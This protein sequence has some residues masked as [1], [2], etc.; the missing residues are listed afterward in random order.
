MAKKRALVCSIH[1]IG[2][3]I[4]TLPLISALHELGYVVDV[5]YSPSRGAATIFK[6]HEKVQRFIDAAVKI[7]DYDVACCTQICMAYHKFCVISQ[8]K[9]MITPGLAPPSAT[10]PLGGYKKHEVA[11]NLD[12]AIQLGYPREKC[13]Y[14]LPTERSD[15][16]LDGKNPVALAIGYLKA[17]DHS[18]MKHWGN[19]RFARFA[20]LLVSCGYTPVLLGGPGDIPDADAIISKAKTE[21]VDCC[22]TESLL[23]T[24]DVLSQCRAIV[25]NETMLVPAASA[26][27]VPCLSLVF[28]EA[29]HFNL[30]KNSPYRC[31]L[32][33][34]CMKA[35]ATPTMVMAWLQQYLLHDE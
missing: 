34:H 29:R 11:Y 2:N 32:A 4:R 20:E 19:E 18:Y 6:K 28:K 14:G 30:R 10:N 15:T 8:H 33:K 23:Q 31:G 17:D 16:R 24:F 27:Q 21:I 25:G 3:C 13:E 1:G 5:R 26:L 12:L 7:A 35:E 9:L 22:G